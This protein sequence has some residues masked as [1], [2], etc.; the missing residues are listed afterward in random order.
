MTIEEYRAIKKEAENNIKLIIQEYE[1]KTC[2]FVE[3]IEIV[4]P[5]IEEKNK[6]DLI[7]KPM[8]IKII[9]VI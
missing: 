9:D 2:A 4:A 8:E 1:A 7:I 5:T 6:K 3:G